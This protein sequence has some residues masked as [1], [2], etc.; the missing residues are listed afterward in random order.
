VDNKTLTGECDI[1]QPY[2]PKSWFS[3]LLYRNPLRGYTNIDDIKYE[4]CKTY[5]PI[6]EIRNTD[7]L[8]N[9][10]FELITLDEGTQTQILPLLEESFHERKKGIIGKMEKEEKI[11]NLLKRILL[12]HLKKRN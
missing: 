12:E 9:R 6:S 5:F 7:T 2:V 11:I 10:G 4:V 8:E 1:C 3:N